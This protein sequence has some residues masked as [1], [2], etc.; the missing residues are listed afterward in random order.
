MNEKQSRAFNILCL[1]AQLPPPTEVELKVARNKELNKMRADR[2]CRYQERSDKDLIAE[3]RLEAAE[4][5]YDAWAHRY[6]VRGA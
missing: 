2:S 1:A 6:Q 5:L 4:S 3:L